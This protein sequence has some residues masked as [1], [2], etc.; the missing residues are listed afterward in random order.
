MPAKSFIGSVEEAARGWYATALRGEVSDANVRAYLHAATQIED[1]WQQTDERLANA[2]AAGTSPWEADAALRYPLASI[3]SARTYQVFVQ[4]LLAMDAAADPATAGY[5]PRVTYDQANALCHQIQPHL[6]EAA[7]SLADPHYEPA[8]TLPL[9]LGPRIEAEGHPCPV[10]HLQGIIAAAHEMRE[11]AAGLLAQYE[12]ALT[13]AQMPIPAEVTI[14]VTALHRAMAEADSQLDFGVNLVGQVS[15]QAP[16]AELHEQAEDQ[17]W[18][19]LSTYFLLN[20]VIAMSDWPNT[21]TVVVRKKGRPKT[22]RDRRITPTDLWRIAAPSAQS[23]LRGTEF[24]TD[25]MAEMCEKMG[26]ILSAGAQQYLD[27]VDA[28]LRQHQVQRIAAMANCPFEPLYRAKSALDVAGAHIPAGH[29]F[30][31]NYHRGHIEMAPRFG[32]VDDWQECEE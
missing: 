9:T 22:Y 31:W 15:Q 27:E 26:G 28:A 1:L 17:L 20:Q 13:R 29:E 6:Q 10:P 7:A 4:Q 19:A 32:R 24:G 5:L 11:W 2:L 23:T 25:E 30:H 3:R 21:A 8:Q 16:N 18:A 12:L 14:H